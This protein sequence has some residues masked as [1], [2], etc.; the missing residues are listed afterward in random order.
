MDVKGKGYIQTSLLTAF[1]LR[2]QHQQRGEMAKLS[3]QF[4]PSSFVPVN[5]SKIKEE[6]MVKTQAIKNITAK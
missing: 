1:F 6:E 3:L 4:L 2:P 5:L